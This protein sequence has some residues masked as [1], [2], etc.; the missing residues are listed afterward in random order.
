[1]V[2]PIN[3]DDGRLLNG[4][5]AGAPIA[6][7]AMVERTAAGTVKGCAGAGLD[8]LGVAVER[9]VENETN[10]GFYNTGDVVLIKPNGWAMCWL[11]GGT[12]ST[13]NAYLKLGGGAYGA[14]TEAVGFLIP[15]ATPATRT[16]NSTG[17]N[18]GDTTTG[19]VG[20]A[21]FDQVLVANAAVGDLTLTLDA[22]KMLALALIPGDYI[23]IDSDAAQEV[24][25]VE[26]VTTTTITLQNPCAAAYTTAATGTVY[27]LRQVKTLLL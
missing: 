7:G 26:S 17:R 2:I 20:H 18:I 11:M 16:V 4:F 27:K 25:R 21:D 1:M 14:T 19:D 22:A 12:T 3:Q 8:Y 5:V 9:E 24:N 10:P 13:T 15:E 6:Y 23:V